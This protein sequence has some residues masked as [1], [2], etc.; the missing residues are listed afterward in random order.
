MYTNNKSLT[1]SLE[2]TQTEFKDFL[3]GKNTHSLSLQ[4]NLT[5]TG[6]SLLEGNL[7]VNT[8]TTVGSNLTVSGNSVLEGNL[9]VNTDTTVGSNL[10]VSG[11]SVLE[12][13]LT[14]SGNSILGGGSTDTVGFFGASGTQRT[15]LEAVGTDLATV[16]TLCNN[17]RDILIA[18]GL[19]AE[20]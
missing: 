18:H 12:G 19:A 17:M 2:K 4:G 16:T 11:N 20:A 5:V 1:S 8:D 14:V 15:V 10:T 13:S 7:T 9:T 6:N 3:S